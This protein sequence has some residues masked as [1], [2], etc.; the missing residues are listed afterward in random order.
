MKTKPR[1]TRVKAPTEPSIGIDVSLDQRNND[2]TAIKPL[3]R[4]MI[5]NKDIQSSSNHKK[6]TMQKHQA[7]NHKKLT[8]LATFMTD[9]KSFNGRIII[10]KFEVPQQQ[11]L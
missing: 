5:D 1:S 4:V 11:S 6:T 2:V 3:G 7:I 8:Y 10:A 9:V